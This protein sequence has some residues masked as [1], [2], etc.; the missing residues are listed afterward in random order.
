MGASPGFINGRRRNVDI[1]AELTAGGF[2]RVMALDGAE[3][4]E[5]DLATIVLAFRCYQGEQAADSGAWIH[6]YYFASQKAYEAAADI[7]RRHA[8]DGVTLRDDIRLKPI[9]ARLPGLTQGR[10]TL[11]YL[12]DVGSRFHVQTLTLMERI[13]S[14]HHLLTAEKP[15]HCGDCRRCEAACPT[16]ALEGGVFHR[17]RCLRN[18]QMSGKPV[19]E[20]LRAH[21]GTMLIGCDICQR[22]CPHNAPVTQA[23]QGLPLTPLLTSPKETAL[24][25][26]PR[27][28]VNL[29]IPNRVLGQSCLL[30]GCSGD[31]SLLPALEKLCTH[32]SPVVAEHAAWAV[33]EIKKEEST[34]N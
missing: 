32:P 8:A 14:T 28:G 2:D 3:C 21:M 15:L 13:P 16:G 34:W 4:G 20:A 12:A 25:L 31:A 22:V 19:P 18:W 11:S 33:S 7:A 30:A 10:N 9:F 5:P 17:E 6:P 29:T 27:I 23:A 24:S 26:R 1:I